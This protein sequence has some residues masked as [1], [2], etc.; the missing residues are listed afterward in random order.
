MYEYRTYYGSFHPEPRFHEGLQAF[1]DRAGRDH[2]K[3]VRLEVVVNPGAQ[4]RI[5]AVVEREPK[6]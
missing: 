3:L 1:L 6:P 5:L 2:F 4:T